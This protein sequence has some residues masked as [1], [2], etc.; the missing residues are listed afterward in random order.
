MLT[1]DP[2]RLTH[3]ADALTINSD[4]TYIE[5]RRQILAYRLGTGTKTPAFVVY[6]TP[7]L[8]WFDDLPDTERNVVTPRTE[9]AQQYPAAK[10]PADLTDADIVD[11]NLLTGSVLPT[12]TGLFRHYF[13]TLPEQTDLKPETLLMLAQ[14]VSQHPLVFQKRYPAQLWQ[15]YLTGFPAELNPLGKGDSDFCRAL[16]EGIYVAGIP[17]LLNEWEHSYGNPFKTKYNVR[18][19]DLLPLIRWTKRSFADDPA[20]ELLLEKRLTEQLNA[21]KGVP[22][23]LLPGLYRAEVKALL[24]VTP[25][26][27]V[28][29]RQQLEVKYADLLTPDLRQRLQELVSPTLPSVPNLSGLSLVQQATAWQQ[30]AVSDFIPYKFWLD[31]VSAPAADQLEAVEQMAEQYSD[32]LFANFASL[33]AQNDVPTNYGVSQTVRNCLATN[34][35]RVIWLIID[36]FPAA[37]VPLLEQALRAHGLSRTATSYAFAPLPTITEVGIPALLN[38]LTPDSSAFTIERHEAL[39]RSFPGYTTAFTASLGQFQ[40][41]LDSYTDLC[42]LHWLDIDETLHRDDTKFDTPRTEKIAE[43]LNDRIGKIAHFINQQTDRPTKLIISTDHGATKCLRNGQKIK[44]VKITEAAAANP[45]ERSVKLEGKLLAMNLD[46]TETYH[47][48]S[49]VTRN[50]TAYVAARG[51]RYFG[52]NDRGY[53]H[54]GLTPEETIVPV[55]LAEMAAFSVE[56]LVLT[57]YGSSDGLPQGKTIKDFGIQVRNPN[58]FAVELLM[59]GVTEDENAQFSL[60]MRV[61]ITSSAT[62]IGSVKIAQKYKPKDGQLPISVSLTYRANAEEFTQQTTITVPIHT[63]ELDEFNFDF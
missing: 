56:P 12:H 42:C 54:G 17:A 8:A 44:N 19:A 31:G 59:L 15:E 20:L 5:A 11:L 36:G 61:E 34:N 63:S 29:Q 46:A 30:W 62:L 48:T 23:N 24:A 16:T 57:Y 2:F 49:D 4:E 14:F 38:G 1:L 21:S 26:M 51:Y 35:S 25:K 33:L 3:S 43:L 39:K 10:I 53:R 55:L 28:D 13:G 40:H 22:K 32:W 18:I 52:S 9:L 50:P 6:E 41:V 7:Y 37:F 45:R 58:S 60:P 47:L 27:T